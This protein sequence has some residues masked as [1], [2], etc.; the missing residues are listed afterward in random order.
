MFTR[1]REEAAPAHWRGSAPLLAQLAL[2][3]DDGRLF[4]NATADLNR[5]RML[6]EAAIA[7]AAG[8]PR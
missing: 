4:E 1:L 6:A 5:T 2:H 3:V 7:R 8:V